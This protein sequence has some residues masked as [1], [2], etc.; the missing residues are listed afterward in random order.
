MTHLDYF[1]EQK[2]CFLLCFVILPRTYVAG[3]ISIFPFQGCLVRALRNQFWISVTHCVRNNEN[4]FFRV[5]L[6]LPRAAAF[7]SKHAAFSSSWLN[8]NWIFLRIKFKF[9]TA[10]ELD[11]LILYFLWWYLIRQN[12]RYRKQ[13]RRNNRSCGLVDLIFGR[14]LVVNSLTPKIWFLTLPSS[15]YTFLCK[16]VKRIS[17]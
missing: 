7:W 14:G 4:T 6:V 2:R 1:Q 13:F 16:L 12:L 17:C 10:V 8:S 3:M 9:Y 11:L 5:T 15:C